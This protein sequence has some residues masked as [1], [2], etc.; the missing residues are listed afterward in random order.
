MTTPT[1]TQYLGL[2]LKTAN[3]QVYVSTA[4]NRGDTIT[5]ELYGYSSTA[6]YAL[7][8]DYPTSVWRGHIFNREDGTFTPGTCPEDV[9]PYIQWSEELD[10]MAVGALKP[11]V[12]HL[13]RHPFNVLGYL[14]PTEYAAAFNKRESAIVDTR[15]DKREHH[16][17]PR[18]LRGA[19]GFM[20]PAEDSSDDD[21]SGASG[22]DE[23]ED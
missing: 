1:P 4:L 22:S 14:K 18:F 9:N 5:P 15:E 21:E 17:P 12:D 6:Y 11:L 16:R 2:I 19:S 8:G 20:A 3:N 7:A 23:T 10:D 13:K